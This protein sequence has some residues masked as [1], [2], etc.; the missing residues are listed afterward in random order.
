MISTNSNGF[1]ALLDQAL[2]CH[3]CCY[4]DFALPFLQLL[5]SFSICLDGKKK[6]LFGRISWGLH[7]HSWVKQYAEIEVYREALRPYPP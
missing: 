1:S 3:T 6:A 5:L 7:T 2:I 4:F